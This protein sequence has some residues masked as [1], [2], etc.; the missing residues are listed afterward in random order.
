[1]LAADL[2][3]WFAKGPASYT[4]ELVANCWVLIAG[5]EWP[6]LADDFKIFVPNPRVRTVAL[7]CLILA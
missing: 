1:M 3:V 5:F 2:V 6:A 4:Q 7:D